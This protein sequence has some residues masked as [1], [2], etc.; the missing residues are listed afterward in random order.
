MDLPNCSLQAADSYMSSQI[1]YATTQY[2]YTHMHS[3][4]ILKFSFI[5]YSNHAL[6]IMAGTPL[7]RVQ[8]QCLKW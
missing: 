7:A 1:W 5:Y 8:C 6:N 3:P 2:D 4:H